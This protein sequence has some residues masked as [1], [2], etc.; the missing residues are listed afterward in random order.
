MEAK[1]S[2]YNSIGVLV[3]LIERQ[4]KRLSQ[5]P[6]ISR[7]I[8]LSRQWGDTRHAVCLIE[9]KVFSSS[10]LEADTFSRRRQR[11]I[12]RVESLPFHQA[13]VQLLASGRKLGL[14]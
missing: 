7:Q 4:S 13:A 12:V 5:T 9:R 11:M 6:L 3:A 8:S 10:G 14:K 2:D 1:P